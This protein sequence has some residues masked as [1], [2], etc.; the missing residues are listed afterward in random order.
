MTFQRSAIVLLAGITF[1]ACGDEATGPDDPDSGGFTAEVSGSQI[2]SLDGSALIGTYTEPQD[3]FL[4][5]LEAETGEQI[6]IG[7]AVLLE[8]GTHSIEDAGAGDNAGIGAIYSVAE[9]QAFGSSG[10]TLRVTATDG[11]RVEGEFQFD[12]TDGSTGDEADVSVSGEFDAAVCTRT[13]CADPAFS[14]Q[15]RQ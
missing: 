10:G 5:Q 12:A 15:P 2:A 6:L 9:T 1:S 14:N 4:L 7:G 3:G 8:A 13:Q 11:D